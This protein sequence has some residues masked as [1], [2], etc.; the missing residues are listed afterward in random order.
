MSTRSLLVSSL[1]IAFAAIPAVAQSAHNDAPVVTPSPD[2]R[3]ENPN[4]ITLGTNPP[5]HLS[6]DPQNR[7]TLQTFPLS[8]LSDA[9]C[10]FI[11]SYQVARDDP[12]S[13]STHLV[14]TSTCQPAR[15]F[16]LKTADL[17]QV[18]AQR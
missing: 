10:L 14:R 13:D 5:I 9:Y 1:L 17:I 6:L 8:N 18:P 15:R 4:T 16:Q 12:H 7:T 11:R 3:S 2:N